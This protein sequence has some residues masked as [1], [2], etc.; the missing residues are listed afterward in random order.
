MNVLPVLDEPVDGPVES[1]RPVGVVV[2][3]RT[4]AEQLLLPGVTV[5]FGKEP[6]VHV[7]RE[8]DAVRIGL[9]VA[10]PAIRYLLDTGARIGPCL[11]CR[12]HST[13]LVPVGLGTADRWMAPGSE[14]H[15]GVT[16]NTLS[17]ATD[18]PRSPCPARFWITP[19]TRRTDAVTTDADRLHQA[20]ALKRSPAARSGRSPVSGAR[21]T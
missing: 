15:R 9:G 19:H 5:G 8:F 20:M 6:P 13:V 4:P 14:C 7:P 2:G 12:Q 16:L 3:Q 17:H 1:V 21:C 10:L 11:V 18:C